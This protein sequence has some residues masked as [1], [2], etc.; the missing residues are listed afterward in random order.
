MKVESASFIYFW[1]STE[2]CAACTVI[3]DLNKT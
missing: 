3:E 1:D 2:L